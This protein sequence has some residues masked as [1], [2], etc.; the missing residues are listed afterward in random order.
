MMKTF[1]N[2]LIKFRNC[3]FERYRADA[4]NKMGFINGTLKF[5]E[6][7]AE[8]KLTEK[9]L[10]MVRRPQYELFEKWT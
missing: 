9:D 10:D 7:S 1:T 3:T 8:A 2:T 5:V 4:K 6:F